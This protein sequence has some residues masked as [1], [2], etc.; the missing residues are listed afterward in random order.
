M[1]QN[2][3]EI[4][5]FPVPFSLYK[6][7]KAYNEKKI[8]SNVYICL[9]NKIILHILNFCCVAMQT[10][11]EFSH[12]FT[13][14]YIFFCFGKV[15]LRY[16]SIIVWSIVNN[17][18]V[19][20]RAISQ[21][22]LIQSDWMNSSQRKQQQQQQQMKTN[23]NSI[24]CLC[25]FASLCNFVKKKWDFDHN[26]ISNI[27]WLVPILKILPIR[28]LVPLSNTRILEISS[29]YLV[30]WIRIRIQLLNVWANT[31]YTYIQF[32]YRQQNI[33]SLITFARV[34][35]TFEL[36]SE[37]PSECVMRNI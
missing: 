12:F 7:H 19:Y 21:L 10:H 9:Q 23:S 22:H 2:Q 26:V 30:K 25:C 1:R 28:K 5:K 11:V 32:R 35:F 17:T 29:Y 37:S 6:C 13:F 31:Q 34:R 24:G 20:V 16:F 18:C 4:E 33:A 36:C 27:L 3:H 15:P 14:K 8:K